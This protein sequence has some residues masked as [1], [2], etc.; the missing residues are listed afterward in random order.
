MKFKCCRLVKAHQV[1]FQDL[2]PQLLKFGIPVSRLSEIL[3]HI[4]VFVQKDAV[5]QP[6]EKN[7]V[8]HFMFIR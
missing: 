5:V 8:N 2:V 1:G 7:A 6:V 3:G 4:D